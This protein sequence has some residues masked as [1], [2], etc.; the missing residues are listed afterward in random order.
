MPGSETH[1]VSSHMSGSLYTWNTDHK[2]KSSNLPTFSQHKQLTDTTIHVSRPKN[3]FPVV[4]R[5]TVGHGPITAFA[6]SPDTT[7]IAVANQDGFLRIYNFHSFELY[8]RMR[9][10]YGGFLCVCW[11][12]DGKYVVTGGEDDLV[13][14]WSYQDK[15]VVTRAEGHHSYVNG[16]SFDPYITES[17]ERRREEEEE[18]AMG[19]AESEL[20]SR[21]R[22]SR[23]FDE[24]S[25]YRVGSVGQD[26]LVCLWEFT[27]DSLTIQR[28]GGWSRTRPTITKQASSGDGLVEEGKEGDKGRPRPRPLTLKEGQSPSDDSAHPESSIGKGGGRSEGREKAKRKLSKQQSSDTADVELTSPVDPLSEGAESSISS[29]SSKSK[30]K[31]SIVKSATKKIKNFVNVGGGGGGV[32]YEG[33]ALSPRHLNNFESC[34]SDDIAP[35]MSEVNMVEPLVCKKVWS[36]RLTDVVFREDCLLLAT[37][38]GFVHLWARPGRSP[39]SPTPSNPGVSDFD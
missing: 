30:K 15:C 37:E 36:E 23:F 28:R 33:D 9:S 29:D 35:K 25:S 3:R 22:S 7:H 8:G 27:S 11:S 1:F 38:D 34:E 17:E 32:G 39:D 20:R 2:Y 18:E 4:N 14:V 24:C 31:K 16:V 13:S 12:P 26:G 10:Y 6:F 19:L 5:W 21:S